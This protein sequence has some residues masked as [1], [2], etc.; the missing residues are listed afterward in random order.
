[1]AS[2]LRYMDKILRF[3]GIGTFTIEPYGENQQIP[4]LAAAGHLTTGRCPS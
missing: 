1:M 4:G 3:S 2:A